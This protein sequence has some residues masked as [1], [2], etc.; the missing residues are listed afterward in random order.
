MEINYLAI[1]VSA[2]MAM[3]MGF[4]WYGPFFGKK[5]MEINNVDAEALKDPVK[6]GEMTK[7]MWKLYVSQFIL[8]LIQIGVFG[9]F[10]IKIPDMNPYSI[11]LLIWFGFLMPT[12]A[13]SSMWNGEST[14]NCI[15]RFSIQ[16]GYLLVMFVIYTLIFEIFN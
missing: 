5:W 11:G 15:I 3:V 12:V 1:I 10:L 8:S 9:C 6:S 16:S 7:G 2:I 4:V 14:K 13:T